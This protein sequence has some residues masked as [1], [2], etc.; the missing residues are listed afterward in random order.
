MVEPIQPA[1]EHTGNLVV[2]S[3]EDKRAPDRKI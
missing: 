1:R 3:R 2:M